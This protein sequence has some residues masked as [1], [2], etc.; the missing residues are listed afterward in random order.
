MPSQK[1]KGRKKQ[2]DHAKAQ[3]TAPPVTVP[4]SMSQA[5][6]QH[7]IANAI[8]EAQKAKEDAKQKQKETN[9]RELQEAIGLKEYNDKNR[10]L[11][12]IK[13]AIN[14]IKCLFK[15]CFLSRKNIKGDRVTLGILSMLLTLIFALV[16][17][18]LY[19]VTFIFFVCGIIALIRGQGAPLWG[20]EWYTFIPFSFAVFILASIFRI[21]SIEIEKVE[22]RD[23]IQSLLNIVL[24]II[25][26]VFAYL[27]LIK[28]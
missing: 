3:P 18:V 14:R 4:A 15:I 8:T 7:I 9:I 26:A 17:L 27:S 5:E 13:I 21:S 20:I 19:V 16:S 23:Y 25:A 28:E 22:D 10:L 24:A 1:S 6:M 2:R 11:R 12:V